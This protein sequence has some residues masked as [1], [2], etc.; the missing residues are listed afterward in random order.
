MPS[1]SSQHVWPDVVDLSS[2]LIF[3]AFILAVPALG[4]V[5]MWLDYKAYLRSLRRYIARI[6]Y[7][8]D[9]EIPA[10]VLQQ[11]PRCIAAFDLEFPCT[12][13]ELKTAYRDKVKQL[14]PDRGGDQQRFLLLQ[15]YFEQ[16]LKI[17][18]E[19]EPA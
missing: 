3:F 8:P 12:E 18:R 13:D 9:E 14:H 5:A 4:Y 16:A 15:G 2:L 10:W 11:T 19:N 1:S 6:T 17:L 7:G